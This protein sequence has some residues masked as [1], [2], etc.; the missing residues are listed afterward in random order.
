[1]A[2]LNSDN[3]TKAKMDEISKDGIQFLDR[4]LLKNHKQRMD[5][6]KNDTKLSWLTPYSDLHYLYIRSFYLTTY[7]LSETLKKVTKIYV[8]ITKA[9]WISYSLPEE[10]MTAL[11][12]NRF[13]EAAAAK[14]TIKSLKETGST[15]KN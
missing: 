2:K 1:L 7:P 10:G 12:L 13:G 8:D 4:K 5:N 9:N 6:L 3:A 11:V 14:M 15:N